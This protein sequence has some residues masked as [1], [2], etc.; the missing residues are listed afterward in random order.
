MPGRYREKITLNQSINHTTK[1]WYSGTYGTCV[2]SPSEP[3]LPWGAY[4]SSTFEKK[5]EKR[6]MTDVVTPGFK[7]II[8]SGGI[9]NNPMKQIIE[10]EDCPKLDLDFTYCS[11]RWGCDPAR[12][13]PYQYGRIAGPVGVTG[14][15]GD[16][17]PLSDAINVDALKDRA[18]SKAWARVSNSEILALATLKEANSTVDGLK[19]ILLKV[20]RVINAI[21]SGN[22][23]RIKKEIKPS[24]LADI[25]M[26]AR[27]N[28]RPLY[29][30]C[31]GMIKAFRKEVAETPERQTF[32]ASISDVGESADSDSFT[33][34]GNPPGWGIDVTTHRRTGVTSRVR[35]G[36]LTEL[37]FLI[38]PQFFGIDEITETVWDLI[39]YSFIIDWFFNVG[40][41]ISSFAPNVGFKT[42]AS[43][44]VV[45]TTTVYTAS[46]T[47]TRP[48]AGTAGSYNYSIVG[49]SFPTGTAQRVVRTIERVPNPDRPLFPRLTLNL[50]PLKL[51]DLGIIMK[52]GRKAQSF[53]TAGM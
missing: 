46:V 21:K 19:D 42:L 36:V 9:I 27:Y 16:Y 15:T 14:I 39:P 30:D 18:I 52:K 47:S 44:V 13:H 51:L 29:Y 8:A 12:W 53:M 38:E 25:Y 11:N 41:V 40:D 45:D 23:R 34:I 17:L 48:F 33:W 1:S 35:A 5:I 49:F 43:W 22:A 20:I 10:K 37:D 32:R 6:S 24:E 26:N 50:D 3:D 4:T 31:I 2:T 28:L 7:K